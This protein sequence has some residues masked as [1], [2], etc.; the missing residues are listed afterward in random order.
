MKN[1]CKNSTSKK[2]I[3]SLIADF[4]YTSVPAGRCI[5]AVSL[6]YWNT[7]NINYLI[8]CV[9]KATPE[10]IILRT[11]KIVS[12]ST[13][14]SQEGVTGFIKC[15]SDFTS[16]ELIDS[17]PHGTLKG[18]WWK[19]LWGRRSL[20]LGD[21]NERKGFL[22][23]EKH[24]VA[25]NSYGSRWLPRQNNVFGCMLLCTTYALLYYLP[26]TWN[27]LTITYHWATG[28]ACQDPAPEGTNPATIALSSCTHT[29]GSQ[30][31]SA[32]KQIQ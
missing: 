24:N 31:P 13:V 9:W 7:H 22:S 10:T 29:K 28:C 26:I 8:I 6:N 30:F 14:F 32:P 19:L 18:S 4:L 3:I 23:V 25:Q 16:W 2:P 12:Y 5:W 21:L 27:L 17:V 20:S 11:K 15:C 1:S